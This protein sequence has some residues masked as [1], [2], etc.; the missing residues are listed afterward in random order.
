MKLSVVI[1]V[2]NEKATVATIVDR[3]RAVDLPLEIIVVDDG[4]TDGTREVLRAIESRVDT[5]ILLDRNRGKGAALKAGFAA[6]TG[7]VVVI[8]DADLEY[9]PQDYLA[10][11][12]PI[13][14]ADADLVLGSRFLRG[15][16][17]ENYPP[18]KLA[19]NRAANLFIRVLFRLSYND[20][21]NAFKAYRA[22]VI[23]GRGPF[24]SA[25]FN[26]TVELPPKAIVRGYSDEVVPISWRQR[27]VGISSLRLREMGSRYLFIVVYLWLERL[28]TGGDYRRSDGEA[29]TPWTP[30]GTGSA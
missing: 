8:Q 28:L 6:A 14:K 13:L 22:S 11:L 30:P 12:D 19:V 2:F 27:E 18:F 16:R 7:D 21:T 1:P 20:V 9:D 25:Q 17:V 24:L 29:F 3:V 15:G 4:S 23:R 10:L 5:V 26:L